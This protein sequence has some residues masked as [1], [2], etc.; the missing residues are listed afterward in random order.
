MSYLPD[1]ARRAWVVP[2]L[3]IRENWKTRLRRAFPLLFRR[4]EHKPCDG[5]YLKKTLP[6]RAKDCPHPVDSLPE[7]GTAPPP[8]FPLQEAAIPLRRADGRLMSTMM[9]R[10]VPAFRGGGLCWSMEE[11]VEDPVWAAGKQVLFPG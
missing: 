9:A 8:L 1:S 10:A 7:A 3:F 5:Q 2:I 4:P 6:W 11:L